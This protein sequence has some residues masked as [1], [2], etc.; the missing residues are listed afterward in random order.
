MPHTNRKKNNHNNAVRSKR[1]LVV[2][3]E[4]GW[5]RVTKQSNNIN[6]HGAPGKRSTTGT[7]TR[8]PLPPLSP[9]SSSIPL[10]RNLITPADASVAKTTVQY[11]IFEQR[12]L[13]SESWT[14]LKA[15]LTNSLSPGNASFPNEGVHH[16][17]PTILISTCIL[18]GSG[19][20]T[21]HAQGWIDRH[22]VALTQIAVFC[23]AVAEPD[24]ND[25]DTAFLRT[26]G[27]ETVQDPAGFEA[28]LDGGGSSSSFVYAPGA[29][30]SVAVRALFE[31]PYLESDNNEK[32]IVE[33][34][35]ADHGVVAIP[36][37]DGAQDYPE[38]RSLQSELE[39]NKGG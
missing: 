1:I 38:T 23:S 20:P 5:T 15:A 36:D 26:L 21:A 39:E 32:D 33:R 30:V 4:T 13:A 11:K 7:R 18:F 8:P 29:E 6:G 24:Y 37:L 16:H 28:L 9:S 27:I 10:P 34:F 35:K 12:W 22:H 14:V 19:S 25:I 17:R 31:Q 3:D 2:E